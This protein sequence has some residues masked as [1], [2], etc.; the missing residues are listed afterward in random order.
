MDL[1]N[2]VKVVFYIVTLQEMVNIASDT[3]LDTLD[4]LDGNK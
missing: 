1:A 3:L 4:F 2:L